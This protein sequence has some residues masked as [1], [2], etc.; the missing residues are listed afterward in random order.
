M[1]GAMLCRLVRLQI[2]LQTFFTSR[3]PLYPPKRYT[4]VPWAVYEVIAERF[5]LLVIEGR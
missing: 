3:C 1:P 5:P 2:R 4:P